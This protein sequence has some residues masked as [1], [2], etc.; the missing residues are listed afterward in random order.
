LRVKYL[1]KVNNKFLRLFLSIGVISVFLLVG[2]AVYRPNAVPVLM[3]HSISD[4]P[5]NPLCVKPSEFE[6]Q[7]HYLHEQQ[8]HS[9]TLAQ[10]ESY[11]YRHQALPKKPFVI[12]FDDGNKDNVS[13]ALPILKKYEFTAAEFVP[14]SFITNEGVTPND[15][16]T[17]DSEGWDIGNHTY[18][19]RK[20]AHL[21]PKEQKDELDKTNDIF[22]KILRGKKV[23]YFSYPEGKYSDSAI[24]TLKKEGFTLAFTTESG[25]ADEDTNS[26]LI[27]RV[28]V[29]PATNL[30]LFKLKV[31]TPF[32]PHVPKRLKKQ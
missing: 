30:E 4:A 10:L 24:D 22:S 29:G 27:P 19:H 6:K 25:W 3:Y 9:V 32:Y 12:T 16:I 7:M 18:S 5:N 28:S 20:M 13:I 14:G 11:L 21:N 15:L 2:L 23:R 17:L 31:N 8:F 1:F 26:Y